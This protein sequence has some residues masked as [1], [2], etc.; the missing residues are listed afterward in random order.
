MYL[1]LSNKKINYI[2]VDSFD[3]YYSDEYDLEEMISEPDDYALT[4]DY[5]RVI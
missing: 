3:L 4:W 1:T 5:Y 2:L